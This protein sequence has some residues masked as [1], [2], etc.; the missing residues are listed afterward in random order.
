MPPALI[1]RT[2]GATLYITRDLAAIL[3]RHETYGANKILYVVG[4]EQQLH[5]K[6]LK[7]LT[8][9]MGLQL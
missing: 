2:D 5:F 8:D 6:Q 3:Y 9:L 7:K 1:K 4:N